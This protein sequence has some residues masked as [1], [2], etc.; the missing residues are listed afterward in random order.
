M[1]EY[2]KKN[3]PIFYNLINNEF[4][5]EK[6]PHAFLLVGNNTEKPLNFL[7]MSL[8]CDETLACM[9]CN[10]CRKVLENKYGDI[11]KFN[12]KDISIKKGDIELIQ[13]T[14][15]KSSLEGKVKIY[16]IENIEYSTK[17]AMNTLLKML[18]EPEEGIYA[19]FTAQNINRV[20]PTI[21]SR[22]QIIDIK[23]D[24]KEIIVK[25][26]KNE[27]IPD[28]V[29]NILSFLTVDINEAREL[30]DERFEFMQVQVI[31]FIEDLYFKRNNL[32]INTQTNLLKKYKERNDIKL[33]LNML[34]LAMKDV[35]HVK[36]QQ[37]ILYSKN[38]DLFKT[39]DVSVENLIKQIELVLETIYVIE[40]NA[41]VALLM[42]SL[43]Y[44]L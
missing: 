36:H 38:I 9:K 7:A 2:L 29:A 44:R 35:F 43:M 14:F 13:N 1:R 15:K 39:I 30:Y 26:L 10:D 32:I 31:N 23:P 5:Q 42:D 28:D 37:K 21:L 34:V 11:L 17:E 40:S 33:F 6:I 12:G 27:N 8:I 19:L 25:Q 18:E 16:I 41:N 4:S 22:C 24:S 20:L 3:Q